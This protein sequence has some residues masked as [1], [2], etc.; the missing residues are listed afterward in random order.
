MRL[1]L[2]AL[3]TFVACGPASPESSGD[4]SG[5]EDETV[6]S[7]DETALG[8]D[9]DRAPGECPSRYGA[10]SP[11]CQQDDHPVGCQ[12]P[13]GTC[14]CG[15][16]M[17]CG[18]AAPEPMPPRWFCEAH[19]TPCEAAGT[20]CSEPGATCATHPCGWDGVQCV[21]GTWQSFHHAGPP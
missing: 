1:T 11:T 18:G 14:T 2:A 7:G 15:T 8:S 4:H 6:V 19:P 9:D 3:V 16:P 10:T 5:D 20:S 17:H 21:D 13:E 12:Y